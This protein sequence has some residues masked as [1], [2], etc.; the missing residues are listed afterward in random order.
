MGRG[1]IP[2]SSCPLVLSH[3]NKRQDCPSYTHGS[4]E[5]EKKYYIYALNRQ[6]GHITVALPCPDRET[7][8]QAFQSAGNNLEGQNF[9]GVLFQFDFVSIDS[10]IRIKYKPLKKKTFLM[11]WLN[12]KDEGLYR[13]DEFDAKDFAIAELQTDKRISEV[14]GHY[15]HEI[16]DDI[17]FMWYVNAALQALPTKVSPARIIKALEPIEEPAG[18]PIF[19]AASREKKTQAKIS[20]LEAYNASKSLEEPPDG[21]ILEGIAPAAASVMEQAA[22][23]GTFRAIA[24]FHEPTDEIELEKIHRLKNDGWS[25]EKIVR[26]VYPDTKE[27]DI[28]SEVNRVKQQHRR[29]YGG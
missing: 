8:R 12:E 23:N 25:W 14:K 28:P 5:V 16:G 3:T 18:P 17:I 13:D 21:M 15:K 29:A 19:I 2:S 22:F 6:T 1:L 27:A 4:L 24:R 20:A 11:G 7:A 10:F 9:S 26:L